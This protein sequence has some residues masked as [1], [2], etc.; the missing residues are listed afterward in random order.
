MSGKSLRTLRLKSLCGG[1]GSFVL[2]ILLAGLAAFTTMAGAPANIAR[3]S[4]PFETN[5]P[6]DFAWREVPPVTSNVLTDV[7]MVSSTDGWVVGR[8]ATLLR[9][10]GTSWTPFPIATRV[11]DE[12]LVDI[13]MVSP[14]DGYIVGWGIRS[15]D[16]TIYHWDGVS[17]TQQYE[18]PVN[19]G[20]PN[21]V[22]AVDANDV[23]VSGR[24]KIYR[25]QNQGQ[26][27][28]NHTI[29]GQNQFNMFAIWMLSSTD[30]W[31]VGQL[32]TML[33]YNGTTWTALNPSP[34]PQTL[35][36]VFFVS[37]QLGLS[38]GF[39]TETYVLKY[40][41]TQWNLEP[42]LPFQMEKMHILSATDGWGVGYDLIAR[43]DGTTFTPVSTT[44]LGMKS[45]YMVS[46]TDGWIVGGGNDINNN[47]FSVMLRYSDQTTP[48]VQPTNTSTVL[49][50]VT[51]IPT[52]TVTSTPITT[53]T[54]MPT[55]TSTPPAPCAIQFSDVHQNNT[56]YSNIRCLA[57][58]GIISGYSDGTFRPNNE[59]T[60]GQLSK[61]VA[62]AAGF[63]EP[64]SNQTFEDVLPNNSFYDFIGRMAARN[65]IG[66]YLCGGP[67]EP[68]LSG[69]PY[70]RPNANATRG[71][72][73]KIVSN[74]AGY[75]EPP[76]SQTFEDVLPS[77]TFYEW[78]ERLASRNAM[79]G[80][81]CGGPSEPCISGKP[82]F[83]WGNNAT[84]G[85]VS[86]IVANTFYPGCVT[87]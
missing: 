63:N 65:I 68:C 42:Y 76:A 33:H 40:N 62:N 31:A 48:T 7:H 53:N 6:S 64:V 59:V 23:W 70:F 12:W 35:Y 29:T 20:E 85:Q 30:G 36:E 86:K 38:S 84:R 55:S 83:R 4:S 79:S 19:G 24:G 47:P 72:I 81:P 73:S 66:G 46:P 45:V 1:A 60:R 52:N 75:N 87:P 8:N 57:C 2:L 14:T 15:G 44:S 58:R 39:S 54:A 25:R 18:I 9:Y 22:H 82:Y 41:G 34:A 49:P 10:N 27:A 80:Y 51:N 69:K 16:G 13:Y 67:G 61:I 77:N 32:G 28:I 21:R 37:P 3:A 56:F 50:T 78:I 5:R 74:A 71:Q 17:W 43:Y 11:A 26:W